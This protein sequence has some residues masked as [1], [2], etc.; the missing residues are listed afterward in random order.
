MD[1]FA[2]K[3]TDPNPATAGTGRA[4]S[5]ALREFVRL[6]AKVAVEKYLHEAAAETEQHSPTARADDGCPDLNEA[7]SGQ[8]GQ[9]VQEGRSHG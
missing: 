7:T 3:I 4:L 1:G 8:A 9:S 6:L 2:N 5:P